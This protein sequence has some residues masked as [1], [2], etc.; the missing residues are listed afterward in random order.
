M[1]SVGCTRVLSV[2]QIWRKSGENTT[3][4]E[5]TDRNDRNKKVEIDLCHIR[6]CKKKHDRVGL[7]IVLKK[8][9]F[10]TL[11][12]FGSFNFV[13]LVLV[14]VKLCTIRVIFFLLL[15]KMS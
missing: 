9:F 13:H 7:G 8:L 3:T 10:K 12:N 1:V 4:S 5:K 2:E 11:L 15:V 6:S 14:F